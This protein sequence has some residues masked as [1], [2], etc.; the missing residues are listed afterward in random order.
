RLTVMI[1]TVYHNYH[2]IVIIITDGAAAVKP[3]AGWPFWCGRGRL[4][5]QQRTAN[6]TQ[7]ANAPDARC[8][9]GADAVVAHQDAKENPEQAEAFAVR[10]LENLPTHG[11]ERIYANRAQRRRGRAAGGVAGGCS[12][13]L[14]ASARLRTGWLGGQC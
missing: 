7:T 6:S 11:A 3:A 1:I 10:C 14:Y 8:W 2:N 4:S 5:P 9:P 12:I 13:D